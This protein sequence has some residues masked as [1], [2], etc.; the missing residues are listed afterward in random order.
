MWS[1]SKAFN[2]ETVG[3][4]TYKSYL[5]KSGL[6]PFASATDRYKTC[7][8]ND[9]PYPVD[10]NA[11]KSFFKITCLTFQ[12]NVF[13]ISYISRLVRALSLVCLAGVFH[14]TAY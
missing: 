4:T 9:F 3:L 6:N 7:K 12:I 5:E 13:I 11:N 14:C 2:G 10:N 8:S 1:S